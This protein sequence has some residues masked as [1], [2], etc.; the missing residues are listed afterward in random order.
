MTG[1]LKSTSTVAVRVKI[2]Q[3][4]SPSKEGP[5]V[6]LLVRGLKA[7][8]PRA[9]LKNEAT[10]LLDNKGPAVGKMRNEAHR[11]SRGST[12][13]N[14]DNRFVLIRANPQ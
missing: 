7:Q 10:D 9:F 6:V 4:P 5:S 3:P 11:A 8:G 13:T 1:F 14:T 12:R 2:Y